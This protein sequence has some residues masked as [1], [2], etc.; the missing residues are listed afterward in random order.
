MVMKAPQ[1]DKLT[2]KL[3][4]IGKKAGAKLEI[5]FL[6]GS[7]A[8]DNGESA[9]EIA[10]YQEYGTSNIPARPFFS[11]CVNQNRKNWTTLLAPALKNAKFD[12]E[13]ALD[14]IGN[15][16]KGDLQETMREWD[17][18]PNAPSTVKAKGFNDP[19]IDTG[20]LLDA[21]SFKVTKK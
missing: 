6:E 1:F 8:G 12:G 21:V 17:T 15:Q 5:G 4:D 13:K 10:A 14:I 20:N 2:H 16:A 7:T 18:P 9:A 19:L 3:R 11:T